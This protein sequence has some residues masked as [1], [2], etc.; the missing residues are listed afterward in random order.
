MVL[1]VGLI[2]AGD[3]LVEPCARQGIIS[4]HLR[5]PAILDLLYTPRIVKTSKM[6]T[7][8]DEGHWLHTASLPRSARISAWFQIF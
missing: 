4:R 1:A 3:A 8:D 2:A 6:T 7:Y 5:M